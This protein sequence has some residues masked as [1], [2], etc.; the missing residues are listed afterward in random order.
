MKEQTLTAERA[1]ELL[2]YDPRTG[3]FRWKV[4]NGGGGKAVGDTAGTMT[5]P[6]YIK[7]RIEGQGYFAHRL[8]WL[9]MT[10]SWPERFIIHRDNDKANNAWANLRPVAKRVGTY[11]RPR[12]ARD[13]A[14][15]P[16][17]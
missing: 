11:G 9:W 7:I 12:D 13:D 6:G 10:G 16:T 2:D 8:A 17:A 3:E 15:R 5:D 14:V 1:R 4:W